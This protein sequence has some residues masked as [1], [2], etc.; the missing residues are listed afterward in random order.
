MQWCMGER[1]PQIFLGGWVEFFSLWTSK[2]KQIT[3]NVV[4]PVAGVQNCSKMRFWP[5]DRTGG[6]YSYPQTP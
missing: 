1:R 6:A 2:S 5:S 4:S 3:Q